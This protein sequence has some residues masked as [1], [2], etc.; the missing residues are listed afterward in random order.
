MS[1]DIIVGFVNETDDE[2]QATLDLL[3]HAQ[4]DSIYSYAYS[5]RNKTRASKMVD[6][7]SDEVRGERL[8]YLQKYQLGIQEKIRQSLVGQDFRVLVDGTSNMGGVKKWKG[9]TN[10][11]RV[12]HFLPDNDE[13]NLL[14][15]WVDVKV[16][17]ATAL[18]CQGNFFKPLDVDYNNFSFFLKQYMINE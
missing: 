6:N 17:S 16:I 1:T 2:F 13:Q 10:C 8:R 12:V 11:N 3:D 15:N 4:F 7:L 18:S 9:R 14:W 5:M